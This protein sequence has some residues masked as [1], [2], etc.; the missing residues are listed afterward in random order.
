MPMF[1]GGVGDL[2]STPDSLE[3]TM[4][5]TMCRRLSC[6]GALQR[7]FNAGDGMLDGSG[8]EDCG[9]AAVI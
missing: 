2:G 7:S 3:V 6:P 1:T 4:E 8:T 5:R 9:D